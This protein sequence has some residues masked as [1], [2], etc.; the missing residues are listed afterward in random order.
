MLATSSL[1]ATA[2]MTH[3]LITWLWRN[4]MMS[5]LCS[6][7]TALRAKNYPR[8]QTL[9]PP[10]VTFVTRPWVITIPVYAVSPPGECESPPLYCSA[11][12]FYK[13]ITSGEQQLQSDSM[14]DVMRCQFPAPC[15]V[16][17]GNDLH[18]SR[19]FWWLVLSVRVLFLDVFWFNH[20]DMLIQ[21]IF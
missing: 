9:W 3:H 12:D 7:A 6:C 1:P 18:F 2:G 4:T 17:T 19:L 13:D 8:Q 11:S 16:K 20:V 21:L 10:A 5:A 15:T 14:H